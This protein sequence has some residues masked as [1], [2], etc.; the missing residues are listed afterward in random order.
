MEGPVGLEDERMPV[1]HTATTPPGEQDTRDEFSPATFLLGSA[2]YIT[3]AITWAWNTTPGRAFLGRY[4]WTVALGVLLAM[5]AVQHNRIRAAVKRISPQR[6]I[7]LIIFSVVPAILVAMSGLFLLRTVELQVAALRAVFLGVVCVLPAVMYYLFIATKKSSLLNEFIIS[8]DRL[9]LL[10]PRHLQSQLLLSGLAKEG[11]KDRHNRILTYVQ[12]FEAVYGAVPTDLSSMVLDPTAPKDRSFSGPSRRIEAAGN[13]FKVDTAIPV[14]IATILVALGWLITLPPWEGQFRLRDNSSLIA[15]ASTAVPQVGTQAPIQPIE[16]ARSWNDRWS[17]AFSPLKT[18]VHFAFIGAYFFSLQ[19]LFRRYVRRDLRASAYV[20]VSQRI[21]LSVIGTWVA[22]EA[23]LL[24][25]GQGNASGTT[26][27]SGWH[28][29]A[30]DLMVLGF[31]IGVFPRVAWQVIQAA[32]KRFTGAALLLPTLQ[33]QLP[34]SDLDGLTVWHEARLE[35]EDIENIPNMSTADLVDLL[36]NTRFPPDRL[37]DWVDQAI[38]YTHLGPAAKKDEPG[39][40]EI[41]RLHGIRTASSLIEVYERSE[42]HRTTEALEKILDG[43][44]SDGPSRLQSLV[45]AVQTNPNL[46]LIQTWRGLHPH[47]HMSALAKA[48]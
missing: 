1:T 17:G 27:S 35:E 36:I 31:V 9:G 46:A 42:K 10:A 34:I 16:P 4:W 30:N 28:L 29:S 39:A 33:A 38:L 21:I 45:D 14:L 19:M 15:L 23:A 24:L 8:L 7:A 12:K 3:I 6:R 22:V 5:G 32:V 13:V 11:E 2:V 47:Q 43:P 40:R 41:L 25:A 37:I 26:D 48:S 18:P 20:A 44:S